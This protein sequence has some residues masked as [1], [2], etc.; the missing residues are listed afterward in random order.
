MSQDANAYMRAASD[1]QKASRVIST[2]KMQE[3]SKRKLLASI[4]KRIMTSFIGALDRI[5]KHI[6]DELWLHGVPPESCDE[7]A[8]SWRRVWAKCRK[9]IL[10]NGN[11]QI[12]GNEH[13]VSIE[14]ELTQYV[15]EY[16]C[17]HVELK[18]CQ[19]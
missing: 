17:Q 19:S 9:D 10:D 2:R 16:S 11:E 5:E 18:G 7:D 15:V 3:A 13:I 8:L 1:G 6:G 14:A 12:M 4:K